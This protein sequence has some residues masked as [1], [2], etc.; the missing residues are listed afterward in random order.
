MLGSLQKTCLIRTFLHL[1]EIMLTA[2]TSGGDILYFL[3]CAS[4]VCN[5]YTELNDPIKQRELFQDQASAKAEGGW[6]L[7]VA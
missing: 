4:Q 7:V 5:A 2:L 6:M 1:L 3:A